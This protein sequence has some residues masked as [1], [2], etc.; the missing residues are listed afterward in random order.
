MAKKKNIR[1]TFCHITCFFFLSLEKLYNISWRKLPVFCYTPTSPCA[2]ERKFH[3]IFLSLNVSDTNHLAII[4]W[5]RITFPPS[6]YDER[7]LTTR[8]HVFQFHTTITFNLSSITSLFFYFSLVSIFFSNIILFFQVRSARNSVPL[9][10]IPLSV[11]HFLLVSA[12]HWKS[13]EEM[14]YT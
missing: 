1:W 12:A 2:Y 11:L 10:V 13:L 3:L 7:A 8:H 6:H 4:G 9:N 14:R 5:K